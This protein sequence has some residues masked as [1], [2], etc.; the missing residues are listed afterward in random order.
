AKKPEQ[1]FPS[2]RAFVEALR[3]RGIPP[4]SPLDQQTEPYVPVQPPPSDV[5][6]AIPRFHYGSQVPLSHFIDREQELAEGLSNL[7]AGDSFLVVG[8]LR[9]GKTSFCRKLT[10]TLASAPG[11][12]LLPAYLNLQMIPTLTVDTFL[13]HTLLTLVGEIARTVFQVG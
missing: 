9:A 13:E 12:T 2:C 1:R 5:P 6:V 8:K 4:L 10:A 7:A 11:P 3:G